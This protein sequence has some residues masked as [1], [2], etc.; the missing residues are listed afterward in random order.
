MLTIYLDYC[1]N[2][3]EFCAW[4]ALPSYKGVLVIK[5][6]SFYPLLEEVGM[7]AEGHLWQ[8]NF[9]CQQG[10]AMVPTC[11]VKHQSVVVIF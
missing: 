2:N 3:L 8:N 10:E 1:F 4:A 6:L 11:L 9:T 7:E 5:F